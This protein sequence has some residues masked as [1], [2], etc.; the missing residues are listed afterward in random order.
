MPTPCRMLFEPLG[1]VLDQPLGLGSKLG[2]N[3]NWIQPDETP[4]CQDC[5]GAMTLVEQ[6]DSFITTNRTIRPSRLPIEEQKFVFGDV[7]MIES[8]GEV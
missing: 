4:C 8:Y 2:G 1:R 3:P 7:G 5:S 6:I